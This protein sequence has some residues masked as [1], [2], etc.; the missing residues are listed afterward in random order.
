M[1]RKCRNLRRRRLCYQSLPPLILR[2]D[3]IVCMHDL[4]PMCFV[5][6]R[7][8]K[9]PPRRGCPRV[10][11]ACAR[12]RAAASTQARGID[13]RAFQNF[14]N[15]RTGSNAF[16]SNLHILIV[17]P[18]TFP[19]TTFTHTPSLAAYTRPC[20]VAIAATQRDFT[21]DRSEDCSASP[22]TQPN[23]PPAR[24]AVH[25]HRPRAPRAPAGSTWRSGP[26]P[27]PPLP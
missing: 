6:P 20:C 8:V 10:T 26:P 19:G 14:V 22:A 25:C 27:T 7:F 15:T 24:R 9:D 17:A 18:C 3:L 21:S 13:G 4:M 12:H 5:S 16:C 11:R 2:A 1:G 23:R